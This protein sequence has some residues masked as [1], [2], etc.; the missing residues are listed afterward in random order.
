MENYKIFY[1][2]EAKNDLKSIYSYIAFELKDRIAAQNQTN[3]IR[4]SI[5]GLDTFPQRNQIVDFEPWLSKG[6]RRLRIDNFIAFYLVDGEEH[7]VDVVRIFY[8]GRDI[9]SILS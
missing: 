7:K 1:S 6:L 3:R 8:G 9:K 5:R 4:E 2:Y